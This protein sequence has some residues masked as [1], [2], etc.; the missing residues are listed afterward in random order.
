M[1]NPS[2][3]YLY[4]IYDGKL[5]MD[6]AD[7]SDHAEQHYAN[8]PKFSARRFVAG[9]PTPLTDVELQA[10]AKQYEVQVDTSP[11][12]ALKP[13]TP[14]AKSTRPPFQSRRPRASVAGVK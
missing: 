7:H 2:Q 5:V 4:H 1:Q 3:W 8:D 12:P 14:P 6:R 11:R 10:L 13:W 9:S